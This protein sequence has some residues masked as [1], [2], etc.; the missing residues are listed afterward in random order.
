MAKIE[1]KLEVFLITYNRRELLKD[2][3]KKILA[4]GSPIKNCALS[5]LDN[6]ST[7]GTSEFLQELLK[8]HPN[9]THIRNKKNIGGNAN[10]LHAYELASKE[11]TWLLCDDDSYDFS[12]W[13]EVEQAINEKA[14]I[15]CVSDFILGK[16]KK[17]DL[18]LQLSFIPAA[19]FRTELLSPSMLRVMYDGVSTMFPQ[20]CPVIQAM[21]TGK[22]IKALS[23][24]IV[25]YRE[26]TPD[27]RD[28]YVRGDKT[29]ELFLRQKNLSWAQGFCEIISQ[30]K[31][32]KTAQ[33]AFYKG[34]KENYRNMSSFVRFCAKRYTG[35]QQMHIVLL[36][37]SQLSFVNKI[38]FLFFFML[39]VLQYKILS[40]FR[41]HKI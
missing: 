36:I 25:R 31:D 21:H 11:Y 20:L 18:L 30:L 35:F 37:A 7:D 23:K 4:E 3:L 14:D 12:S 22:K 29:E 41:N 28:S 6:C 13:T 5:I 38:Y 15:I 16:R 39:K 2:T 17:S 34:L 19:I 24:G 26:E 9:I 32:K 8:K 10:A 27:R 1:N 40:T 33:D